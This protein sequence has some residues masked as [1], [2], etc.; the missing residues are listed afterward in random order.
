MFPQR[1]NKTNIDYYE[2]TGRELFNEG[3]PVNF[4]AI[5]KE[6]AERSLSGLKGSRCE[7]I[8]KGDMGKVL[9]FAGSEGMCGA[10]IIAA[11]AAFRCGSG[12]VQIAVGRELFPI[13]QVGIPEA[14]CLDMNLISDGDKS[15]EF[16]FKNYDAAC[17]GPGIGKGVSAECAL[18]K[19]IHEFKS[20]LII[21]ADGLNLLASCN[22]FEAV[23]NRSSVG[24]ETVIL[25]HEGEAKRLLLAGGI[26]ENSINKMTRK[27]TV[28]MLF[29]LTG[30][31]SVL[32]GYGTLVYDGTEIY[33]N[34][35][36]NRGMAT[37]GSG[38]CL[39]GV[40]LSLIGQGMSAKEAALCGV[41]LHGTAGDIAAAR[42][43]FRS[44][45]AS[46]IVDSLSMALKN[47]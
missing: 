45:M 12:L 2:K 32:K 44:V 20:P 38:D 35:T 25:P 5:K 47:F 11:K 9:L 21:D 26:S 28:E 19:M 14:T 4:V 31:V 40:V 3:N 36:G 16:S 37:A 17:I 34:D 46:D 30:A 1:E 22:L 6:M 27:Q 39:S 18:K 24:L 23:K 42:L 10:A 29:E 8:H 43:G 7:D 13:I 41:F 15:K 33:I